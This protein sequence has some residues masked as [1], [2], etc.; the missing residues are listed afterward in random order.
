MLFFLGF[1]CHEKESATDKASEEIE[2]QED[3]RIKP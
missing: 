3:E 2:K 1:L